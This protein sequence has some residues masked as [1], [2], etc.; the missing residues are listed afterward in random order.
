MERKSFENA[1]CAIA[2]SLDVVG[3]WWTP[4]IIRESLYGVTRF[5]ELQRW[6]GIGRNILAK[7]LQRLVEQEVLQR[8]CYQDRPPRYEYHLTDKGYD[9]ATFLLGLMPFGEQWFFEPGDEPIRLYDRRTNQ[10]VRPL[11][12]DADTGEPLDA[13]QLYAGPGPSFRYPD[14]VRRER[15]KEYYDRRTQRT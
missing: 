1:A 10:R 8:R 2:R 13:R 7:R 9:A 12:T 14:E 15:F 4:M 5:D 6:L 3:D 11:L